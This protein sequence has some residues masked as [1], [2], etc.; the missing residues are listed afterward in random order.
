MKRQ[1]RRDE[2]EDNLLQIEQQQPPCYQ[3]DPFLLTIMTKYV[4]E[5]TN[6]YF[7]F[8][9]WHRT[10]KTA[11]QP[12]EECLYGEYTLKFIID[13]RCR[14]D[15]AY[16]Q[17]LH[18][19]YLTQFVIY[20]LV[21]HAIPVMIAIRDKLK[22]SPSTE[23]GLT[24]SMDFKCQWKGAR[25]PVCK[26]NEEFCL[27][28]LGVKV[29]NLVAYYAR[30]RYGLYMWIHDVKKDRLVEGT[31][32]ILG[33]NAAPGETPLLRFFPVKNH[34]SPDIVKTLTRL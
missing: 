14:S 6:D 19:T 25:D 24:T 13:A 2:N 23:F 32:A 11:W 7:D 18:P 4:L 29:L 27:T 31:P 5:V 10:C 26:K 12:L 28:G 30:V 20:G 15:H 8:I 34:N 3:T 17:S 16:K 33:G 1:R 9:N 22:R 21:Q